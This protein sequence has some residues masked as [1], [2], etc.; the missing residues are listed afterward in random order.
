MH[1]N[2][3]YLT[4]KV[5]DTTLEVESIPIFEAIIDDNLA[6]LSHLIN[7]VAYA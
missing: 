6:E 1:A 3:D 2:V 5:A 7:E 4:S